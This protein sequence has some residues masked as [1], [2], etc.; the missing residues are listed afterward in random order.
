M[1]VHCI[2][3]RAYHS[4]KSKI[5][6]CVDGATNDEVIPDI[7]TTT[8]QLRSKFSTK[9]FPELVDRNAL[10]NGHDYACYR[11][12]DDEDETGLEYA[13]EL[14]DWEDAIHEA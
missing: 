2:S 13:S 10:K 9:S 14:D 11:E 1:L 12:G 4:Q 3:G 8:T 6:E 7:D 5:S